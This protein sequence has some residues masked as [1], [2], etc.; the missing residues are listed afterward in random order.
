MK[1]RDKKLWVLYFS[2]GGFT[3]LLEF[4]VLVVFNG[5]AYFPRILKNVYFDNIMG[6]VFSDAFTIPMTTSF[7]AGLKL[8][9]VKRVLLA[10]AIVAIEIVFLNIK[11]YEHYWW[12]LAFTFIGAVV[13]YSYSQK[14]LSIIHGQTSRIINYI[15]LFFFNIFIQN[16]MAFVLAGVLN[17]FFYNVP[18]FG[19]QTRGHIAFSTTYILFM[20]SI[21]SALVVFRLSWF[22][23]VLALV[24]PSIIDVVLFKMNILHIF[25]NWS[26]MNFFFIRVL[27]LIILYLYNKHLLSEVN[28]W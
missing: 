18:W 9:F 26:L 21:F 6:A 19:N 23:T 13:V 27:I 2:V 11:I 15:N 7:A 5:Y 4:F 25:D 8:N 3:Y 10:A 20:A 14:W 22:W 24:L 28:V 12:N 1:K 17:L 16:S